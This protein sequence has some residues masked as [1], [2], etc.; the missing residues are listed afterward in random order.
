MLRT[1]GPGG[2]PST[3][4]ACPVPA[5]F[6]SIHPFDLYYFLVADVTNGHKLADFKELKFAISELSLR[7]RDPERV[8]PD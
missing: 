4:M 7:V 6:A 3:H 8:S 1:E 2:A 5:G